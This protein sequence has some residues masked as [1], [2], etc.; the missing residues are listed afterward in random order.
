MTRARL[1]PRVA[2]SSLSL[3]ARM[4]AGVPPGPRPAWSAS[5]AAVVTDNRSTA[6]ICGMFILSSAVSDAV[7]HNNTRYIYRLRSISISSYYILI[8][9]YVYVLN[10]VSTSVLTTLYEGLVKLRTKSIFI[11]HQIAR[12][13][14]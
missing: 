3:A 13:P 10:L 9:K 2:S 5:P 6:S 1:M 4:S 12:T 7:T 11:A 14:A 8:C